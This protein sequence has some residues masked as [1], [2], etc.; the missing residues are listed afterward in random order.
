MGGGFL[1]PIQNECANLSMECRSCAGRRHE[2]EGGALVLRALGRLSRVQRIDLTSFEAIR[3]L[4]IL[5]P[6][7]SY[8][9]CR[10]EHESAKSARCTRQWT[11]PCLTTL[12]I[13][14]GSYVL[15]VG[16]RNGIDILTLRQCKYD[17]WGFDGSIHFPKIFRISRRATSETLFPDSPFD[18]VISLEVIEA[19]LLSTPDKSCQL[20]RGR[21]PPP[22]P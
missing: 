19:E 12:G 1:G 5:N 14:S 20:N 13:G 7:E 15:S 3:F 22:A 8:E 9:F 4:A 16:C 21:S 18:A 2:S 6:I 17:A 11:I 10:T